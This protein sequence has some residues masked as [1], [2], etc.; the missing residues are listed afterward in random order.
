[1]NTI[2]QKLLMALMTGFENTGISRSRI[3]VAL[4][5]SFAIGIFIHVIY[6][7]CS[8]NNL[9]SKSFNTT[10]ALITP[11]MAAIVMTMQSSLIISLSSIG[12]LSI[13]RFRTPIKDPMDL[14]YLFWSI[15]CGI[16]CGAGVYEIA[17]WTV[18]IVTFAILFL[19][20]I[21]AKKDG[22]ILVINGLG[23]FPRKELAEILTKESKQYRLRSESIMNDHFDV[24]Y[25]I[26]IKNEAG[27]ADKIH[28]VKGITNVSLIT[29]QN[30]IDG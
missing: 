6:R 26:R 11:M 22:Y 16:M 10:L 23:A 24:V 7:I 13:I 25:E 29:Q 17:L 1:M 20:M 28:D 14:V 19:N 30:E 21:P 4:G 18:V 3:L 2:I 5:L 15:S 27:L 8:R 12:A 9:Y